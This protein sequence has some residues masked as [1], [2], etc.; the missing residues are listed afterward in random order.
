MRAKEMTLQDLLSGEVVYVTPSFQRSYGG[1][2]G[3]VGQLLSAAFSHEN[4]PCLLGAIVTRDLVHRD[5]FRK[6]LLID[7][8]Q[9]LA[10]LLIV[11]LALRDALR[12]GHPDSA[13]RIDAACFLNADPATPARFKNLVARRDRSTFE[14][15]V[16][17]K[18]FPDTAHPMAQ[19]YAQAAEAFST[20]PPESL[21]ALTERFLLG[22]TFVVF[23]LAPEDD[24]YPVFR[25]F[26]PGDDPFTRLGRDTYRQFASDPELMD[27]IAGGESQ[28]VEFKAHAIVT[29]KAG[30]DEGPHGVGTVIRGVAA[31]LN[32]ATGGTLLIG[33]EDDGAICGVESE[34]PL[35]DRG[36]SNWDGYQLCLAN[37]LRARLSA[38]NAFLSYALERRRAG[39]H[40]V[41]MIRVQPSAEPVYIDKRLFVR[42][43]NQTVEML[44]PDLID[45]VERRFEPKKP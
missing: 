31:M 30:R 40:D 3:Q 9:R 32:S 39:S 23:A 2:D 19:T 28:E 18:G 10:T 1:V 11:L 16:A 27:L 17:G 44:G 15:G 36:K 7:G 8:N 6:A 43:L 13:S 20:L 42:T 35:A 21:P 14:G 38:R 41:C 37:M 24:P 12:G 5:N 4:A 29:G 33:V 25:L 26:N 22:F 45:Y 34:Y